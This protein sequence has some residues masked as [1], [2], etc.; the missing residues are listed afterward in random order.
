MFTSSSP[1]LIPLDFKM[2]QIKR[3]YYKQ[4][5]TKNWFDIFHEHNELIIGL[6]IIICI[7]GILYIKYIDKQKINSLT[8]IKP[9]SYNVNP[10]QL[11]IFINDSNLKRT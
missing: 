9:I 1:N 2:K 10:S 4:K 6:T 8:Y 5:L 3:T 11:P 7:G